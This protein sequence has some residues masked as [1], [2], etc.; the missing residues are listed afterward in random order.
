MRM[1]LVGCRQPGPGNGRVIMKSTTLAIL[2]A[3]IALVLFLLVPSLSW[4]ADDG[5]TVHKN[6][7]RAGNSGNV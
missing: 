6:N 5:G 7:Y 1:D 2:I 4:V 3:A